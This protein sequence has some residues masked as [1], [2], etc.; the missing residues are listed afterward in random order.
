VGKGEKI[1]VSYFMQRI[2]AEIDFVKEGRLGAHVY[3]KSSYA[4]L[5]FMGILRDE[6]LL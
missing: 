6:C 1:R 2:R 4:D 5:I 3:S